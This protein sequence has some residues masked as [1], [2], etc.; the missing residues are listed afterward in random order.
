MTKSKNA[1]KPLTGQ[2]LQYCEH[3]C[4]HGNPT[5]AYCETLPDTA[6]PADAASKLMKRATCRSTSRTCSTRYR[7]R[8]PSVR[9][10]R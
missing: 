5:Q 1:A 9:L 2:E 10:R 6:R 4:I 3:Y 7:R 8:R